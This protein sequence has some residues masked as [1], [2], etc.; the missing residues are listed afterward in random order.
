[1]EVRVFHGVGCVVAEVKSDTLYSV[2]PIVDDTTF[3]DFTDTN[4]RFPI[5]LIRTPKRVGNA[6]TKIMFDDRGVDKTGKELP[7][8]ALACA[9]PLAITSIGSGQANDPTVGA[10]VGGVYI[11]HA[12]FAKLSSRFGS[13]PKPYHELVEVTSSVYVDDEASPPTFRRYH[14]FLGTVTKVAGQTIT[15]RLDN[16]LDGNDK[17]ISITLKQG[18]ATAYDP[19]PPPEALGGQPSLASNLTNG[20]SGAVFLELHTA[21]AQGIHAPKLPVGFDV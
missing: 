10:F 14:G 5:D 17:P 9:R 16:E 19:A 2:I 21:V 12:Q 13:W 15:V 1:M 8:E 3:V 6:W 20:A 18:D 11:E 4:L 7:A